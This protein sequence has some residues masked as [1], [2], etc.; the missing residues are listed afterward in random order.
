[1]KQCK[2]KTKRSGRG[3]VRQCE[4]MNG[5]LH[6][7]I[8]P[9]LCIQW[10]CVCVCV[11]VCVA[12]LWHCVWHATLMQINKFV[13]LRIRSRSGSSICEHN[14]IRRGCKQCGGSS[15]CQHNRIRRKCKQCAGSGICEHN[16]Q[17]SDCKQCG[18]SSICEH[19]VTVNDSRSVP[20]HTIYD[21][22]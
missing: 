16:R 15:I 17:R 5:T 14:R 19:T 1:M 3:R 2:Y 22:N 20:D 13:C 21:T 4:C 11:C 10:V 7:F 8:P 18:G 6:V 9:T 12:G